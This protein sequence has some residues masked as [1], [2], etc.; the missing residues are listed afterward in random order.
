[1]ISTIVA[2]VVSLLLARPLA[3][4]LDGWFGFAE[5]LGG[6]FRDGGALDQVTGDGSRGMLFLIVICSV[7]V[8]VLM[9]ILFWYL[10]KLALR[11]KERNPFI[12]QWDRAL[13]AVFGLVRF[14]IVLTVF[15]GLMMIIT[16]ISAF[17][18][19]H[20]TIFD[21]STVAHWFYQRGV[22]IVVAIFGQIDLVA[23]IRG[24]R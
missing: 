4:L 22:D 21:N 17:E 24:S 19:L 11:L 5:R 2:I 3:R 10:K 7:A 23:A 16:S 14:V 18:G 1:M 15:S 13:G 12:N 6:V 20:N 9:K 8:F